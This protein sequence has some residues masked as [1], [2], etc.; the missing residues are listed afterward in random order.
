M[1]YN[2]S[3]GQAPVWSNGDK[4]VSISVNNWKWSDGESVTAADVA[5]VREL[6][7]RGLASRAAG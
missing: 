6:R 4:T 1:D 5:L 7:E 3:V 2:Y